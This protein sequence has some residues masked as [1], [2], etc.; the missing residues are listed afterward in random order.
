MPF[1]VL[2][3]CRRGST[4]WRLAIATTHNAFILR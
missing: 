3:N 2:M 1:V 4:G